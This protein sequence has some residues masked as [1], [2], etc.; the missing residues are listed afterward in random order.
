VIHVG[1]DATRTCFN[2]EVG[3]FRD[4]YHEIPDVSRKVFTKAET[5]KEWGKSPARLDSSLDVDDLVKRASS[6]LGKIPV[7]LQVSDDVGNFVCGFIYY[8]SLE[9]FSRKN[10]DAERPVLFLH[11]PELKGSKDIEI[12]EKVT[13]AL[14]K[15]IA[16]SFQK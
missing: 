2:L 8:T 6:Q 10:K 13:I 5:K 9:H 4:G 7:E 16:E 15:A 1:L 14:I 11:V 3:A 12:G